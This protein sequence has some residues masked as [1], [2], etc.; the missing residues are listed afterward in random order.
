MLCTLTLKEQL[1][2]RTGRMRE[3]REQWEGGPQ[4]IA[5]NVAEK[6]SRLVYSSEEPVVS[7]SNT[8]KIFEHEQTGL[9]NRILTWFGRAPV[10]DQI[11]VDGMRLQQLY[12][13]ARTKSPADIKLTMM[14]ALQVDVFRALLRSAK[15]NMARSG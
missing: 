14:Y 4:D 9:W 15:S 6:A 1:A 11:E 3:I 8:L 7:L 13:L 12:E 5:E 2:A 10:T